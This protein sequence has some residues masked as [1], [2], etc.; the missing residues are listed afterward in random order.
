MQNFEDFW[1]RMFI[2]WSWA[3]F[4]FFGKVRFTF[5]AFIWA[6]FIDFIDFDA[7]V[8]KYSLKGEHKNIMCNRDQGH[9]LT[10]KL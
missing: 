5:W 9:H 6:T 3:D 10:F 2:W 7:K 8:D 1:P 4:D